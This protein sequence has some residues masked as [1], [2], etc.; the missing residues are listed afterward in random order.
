MKFEVR[1]DLRKHRVEHGGKP[2]KVK[3]EWMCNICGKMLKTSWSY[4]LHANV[5]EI[6]DEKKE[7][8]ENKGWVCQVLLSSL[9]HLFIHVYSFDLRSFIIV[10]FI[11]RVD[12]IWNA[13]F[14][15][16]CQ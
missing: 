5:H 4:K 13:N 16:R 6:N 9:Q 12:L 1:L 15:I 3:S 14:F 10:R 2:Y 8:T 7:D 11:L